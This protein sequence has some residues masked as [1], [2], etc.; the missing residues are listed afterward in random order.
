MTW[1]LA[2]A[3]IRLPEVWLSVF[4]MAGVLWIGGQFKGWNW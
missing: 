1:E 2:W 4:V 3:I